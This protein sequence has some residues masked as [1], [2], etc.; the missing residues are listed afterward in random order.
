[1]LF[2]SF[3]SQA[4]K[5]YI[6]HFCCYDKELRA[7]IKACD[8]ANWMNHSDK[9][10]LNSPT[11]YTHIANQNINKGEELTV[12]YRQIE[13]DVKEINFKRGING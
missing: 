10:N 9:P 7:W 11:Y 12:D 3:F 8:N 6:E 1:M 4:T 13:D 5:D 2:R